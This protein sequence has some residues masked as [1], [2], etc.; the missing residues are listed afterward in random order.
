MLNTSYSNKAAGYSEMYHG[1]H[2]CILET[3][4]SQTMHSDRILFP[5]DAI[6]ETNPLIDSFVSCIT[7]L[8]IS[9]TVFLSFF[10][11]L[12]FAFFLHPI[13]DAFYSREKRLLALS[14]VCPSVRM[15][16]VWPHRADF[17]D[18]WYLKICPGNQSVVK[19]GQKYTVPKVCLYWEQYET[20]VAVQQCTWHP[21][22]RLY[23][24]IHP[25]YTEWRTKNRP[26]VS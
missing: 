20:F 17:R 3:L 26:A 4:Y 18:I 7:C 23:D 25:C 12:F 15:Y 10:H 6:G 21:L 8:L 13:L 9:S 11:P 14:C 5:G 16:Q 1:R 2:A 22:L 24:N 19:I